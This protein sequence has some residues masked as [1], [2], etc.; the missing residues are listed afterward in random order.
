MGKY[1]YAV[2][3]YSVRHDVAKDLT[4]S[5]QKVKDLGYDGVEFAGEFQY[6]A[7]EVKDALAQTGLAVCG[8][9]TPWAYVQDD[10]F[11]ATVEYFKT[12]G[13]T[14]VIIPG[15][16]GG[17]LDT[18]EAVLET[19]K[20]FNALAQKLAP[21]GMKLGYHNHNAE[22]KFF[23]GTDECPLTVFFDNTCDDV[24]VQLDNGNA[25]SALGYGILSIIRRYP[26]RLGTVHLKPY[27]VH[28][29]AVNRDRGFECIIGE[30]DVPWR[31]F[32]TLCRTVGGTDWYIVEY[33]AEKLFPGFEGLGM[34]IDNLKALEANGEI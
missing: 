13:N 11:D 14:N 25:Y 26:N 32:M 3:L 21:H 17:M 9:H 33:E 16:P 27:S 4:G 34:C 10:T 20:L 2:E 30:D 1:K 31:D 28:K 7:A 12:V 15:L 6:T 5:L 23:E 18:K 8:W 29:G 22:L 19:A 24:I